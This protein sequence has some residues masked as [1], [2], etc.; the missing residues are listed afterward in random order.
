M[1]HFNINKFLDRLLA[2][3]SWSK[4]KNVNISEQDII[5]L[6]ELAKIS[7][8]E[9]PTLLEIESPVN[10][11]GDIHGQYSDLLRLFEIGGFP[12]FRKYLFLGDYVD[13]GDNSLEVICLLLTYKVKYPDHF[14]ILRG[15]HED[16]KIN[17]MY[18]FYAE[19]DRRLG[20]HSFK[21]Y[22]L[23]NSVF[24]CIPLAGV[25]NNRYFC[26]HG[27]IGPEL[28]NLQQIRN[29]H[30]PVAIPNDGL[31]CD[32]VWSDPDTTIAEWE[33]QDEP[34]TNPKHRGQGFLFG[35]NVLTEFLDNNKLT[36]IFRAHQVK[37]NGYEFF[38]NRRLVTV[39]SAPNYNHQYHNYGAIA[40][41]GK[42][43]DGKISFQKFK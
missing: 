3:R 7:L 41:I 38:G 14:F 25:V 19:C 13:R 11:C 9:Q 12:P 5:G 27:G 23:L 20:D 26:C 18:G 2:V 28:K 35:V 32:L 8:L 29:I 22:K 43:H 1:V 31:I 33:K 21:L 39:F 10:I 42:G 15:N 34:D 6:C 30:R 4:R 37:Q 17:R 24:N 36:M 16:R 40:R